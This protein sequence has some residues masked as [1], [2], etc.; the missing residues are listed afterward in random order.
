[1][2]LLLLDNDSQ[3]NHGRSG[4][5]AQRSHLRGGKGAIDGGYA[6]DHEYTDVD[7]N[8]PEE[9]GRFEYIDKIFDKYQDENI[10]ENIGDSVIDAHNITNMS[11]DGYWSKSKSQHSVNHI[12]DQS[13][14]TP[15]ISAAAI[16]KG[17]R[18]LPLSNWKTKLLFPVEIMR[19]EDV[20]DNV[21]PSPV[22]SFS[23][24]GIKDKNVQI[25]AEEKYDSR[26]SIRSIP[27]SKYFP[28][29]GA[30]LVTGM[31]KLDHLADLQL[32]VLSA[33]KVPSSLGS[34]VGVRGI[35]FHKLGRMSLIANAEDRDA[36]LR[37]DKTLETRTTATQA[38]NSSSIGLNLNED[39]D[40]GSYWYSLPYDGL[41]IEAA[42]MIV[43]HLPYR[44][45]RTRRFFDIVMKTKCVFTLDLLA[46]KDEKGG[47]TMAGTL[48]SP[49]CAKYVNELSVSFV[50][51]LGEGYSNVLWN[52]KDSKAESNRAK[53]ITT[54]ALNYSFVMM[55]VCI[56]QIVF[57]LRQL[58]HTSSP[59]LLRK[60]SLITIGWQ[61]GLDA[62]LS[63]IHVIV[64]LVVDRVFTA[65]AS[66]AF[67]KLLLF[68]VIEMK[69][70]AMIMQSREENAGPATRESLRRHEGKL[71]V[72]FYLGF[73]LSMFLFSILLS[74]E[75][76]HRAM[77]CAFLLVLSYSFWVPQIILNAITEAKQPLINQ[78]VYVMSITRLVAPLYFFAVSSSSTEDS[79]NFFTDSKLFA[80]IAPMNSFNLNNLYIYEALVLWVGLQTGILI[81]QSKYGGRFFIPKRFLPPKFDYTRSIPMSVLEN[82]RKISESDNEEQDVEAGAD[83]S[84]SGGSRH[85]RHHSDPSL[86]T[87]SG[88]SPLNGE[89]TG[90]PSRIRNVF[91][92]AMRSARNRKQSTQRQQQSSFSTCQDDHNDE[93]AGRVLDCVICCSDITPNEIRSKRYMLA[94]CNHVFHKSCLSS[95]MDVKMECPVCRT[96]LPSV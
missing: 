17:Y 79:P 50:E 95:W 3:T 63:L 42:R 46:S 16:P 89:L 83:N 36:F 87:L 14:F 31:L 51:M 67:F 81:A 26:L 65:M 49:N 40:V 9:V 23:P 8:N 44:E 22:K 58:I 24:E 94:P 41:K 4:G 37:I 20:D 77:T 62:Y 5:V 84:T 10:D 39:V 6:Y 52:D 85:Y 93:S 90:S 75:S 57:L 60:V 15:E 18:P 28:V 69:Y 13:E 80:N 27:Q 43:S 1:M 76:E 61:T 64:S 88:P 2:I 55:I 78:Y 54:Q 92:T 25:Q 12:M 38:S 7:K 96:E 82:G 56:T 35:Y 68:C 11:F 19:S 29:S 30:T 71:H 34:L 70:M 72:R 91:A 86:S 33:S 48:T 32:N 73:F 59:N 53:Q 47:M 74:G 45:A 21:D 66:V